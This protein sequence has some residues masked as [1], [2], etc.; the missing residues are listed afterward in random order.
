MR[1][2]EMFTLTFPNLLANAA[3]KSIEK[4]A[5]NVVMKNKVPILLSGRPNL[6]WK[7]KVIH[8]LRRSAERYQVSEGWMTY[9]GARLLPNDSK[10]KR[11]QIL[12]TTNLLLRL[13]FGIFESMKFPLYNFSPS[14]D[15]VSR[16]SAGSFT[17]SHSLLRD[18]TMQIITTPSPA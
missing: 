8:D 13:K 12:A 14:V 1:S 7:K 9:N 17:I 2:S 18:R 16:S 15:E 11:A 10:A 4:A 3:A 6:S 5:T